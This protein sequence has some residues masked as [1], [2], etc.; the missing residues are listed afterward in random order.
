VFEHKIVRRDKVL[1]SSCNG[2]SNVQG[3]LAPQAL[4]AKRVCHAQDGRR[5]LDINHCARFPPRDCPSPFIEGIH[6]ILVIQYVRPRKPDLPQE[7]LLLNMK[8][9]F[10]LQ[11]DPDLA[12]VVEGPMETTVIELV[13]DPNRLI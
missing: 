7:N 2:A 1:A 3:I 5:F 9:G 11:T 13:L 4:P 12:L 6:L 8:L 10:G